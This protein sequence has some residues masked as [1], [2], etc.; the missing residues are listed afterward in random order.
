MKKMRDSICASLC[1]SACAALTLGSVLV[2]PAAAQ[3]TAA[4]AS[5]TATATAKNKDTGVSGANLSISS[6][7]ANGLTVQDLSCK[8]AS[9]GLLGALEI[10][11]SLSSQKA[12]LAKCEPAGGR[13]RVLWTLAKGH[14]KVSRVDN[15]SSA[16]AE[17]CI[18]A[19]V[20]RVT[21]SLEGTCSVVLVLEKP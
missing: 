2:A 21:S 1:A 20:G 6:M 8:L 3:K 16:A 9:L 7:S 17:A 14:A 18:T 13:P 19:A 10:V 5:P 12:A 4:G 11:G 15:A